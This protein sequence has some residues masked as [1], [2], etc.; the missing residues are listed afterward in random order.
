[1]FTFRTI[2]HRKS[3]PIV[4]PKTLNAIADRNATLVAREVHLHI[5]QF[6]DKATM[7]DEIK[8]EPKLCCRIM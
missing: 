8:E 5:K 1:M 2:P 7:T 6:E 4:S 3:E